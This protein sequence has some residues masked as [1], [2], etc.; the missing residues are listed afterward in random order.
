ED[1]IRDRNVTGVQTCALPICPTRKRTTG[2]PIVRFLVGLSGGG[3][4]RVVRFDWRGTG[5][6]DREVGDVSAAKR[7]ADLEAVVDA[8][9]GEKDRKSVVEGERVGV[10]GGGGR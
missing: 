8:M 3:R 2:E 5:L 4:R 1:G 10:G 7:A 9:G 6:S